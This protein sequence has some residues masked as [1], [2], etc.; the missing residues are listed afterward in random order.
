MSNAKLNEILNEI[1]LRAYQVEEKENKKSTKYVFISMYHADNKYLELLKA[2]Y[3]FNKSQ[4]IRN[5]IEL[6]IERIGKFEK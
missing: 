3:G 1:K 4:I 6:F 5:A 2:K